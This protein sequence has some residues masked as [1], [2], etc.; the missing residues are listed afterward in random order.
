M[1]PTE[2]RYGT[3]KSTFSETFKFNTSVSPL[4][5]PT[6]PSSATTFT[7]ST[8]GPASNTSLCSNGCAVLS[9]HFIDN[10]AAYYTSAALQTFSA[11]VN[12]M[13]ATVA[14]SYAIDNPAQVPV[15]VQVFVTDGWKWGTPTTVGGTGL[16]AYSP[17]TGFAAETLSP[18]DNPNGFCASATKVVGLQ[19]QNATPITSTTAG[20]VTIYIASLGI[21]V[22]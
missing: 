4:E 5:V 14:F 10:Q 3:T 6:T 13:G 11:P 15:Q 12:L 2:F 16:A 19:V 20:T 9:V 17:P 21:T 8:T 18:V 7:F 1:P 22:P